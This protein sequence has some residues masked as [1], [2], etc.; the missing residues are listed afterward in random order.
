MTTITV[1]LA[2]D[3]RAIRRGV[4]V[5]LGVEHDIA[6]IAEAE[7]GAEA[8]ELSRLHRPDVILMDVQMPGVNGFDAT[9]QVCEL[10]PDTKVV[11]MSSQTESDTV[12]RAVAAGASGFVSKQNAL[13]SL[14]RAIREVFQGHQF[15][16]LSAP[17]RHTGTR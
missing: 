1:L 4:K 17:L 15:L 3:H 16:G 13:L 7:N 6:V 14:P 9:R 12:E 11:M 8:V 10:L 5:L 2:D